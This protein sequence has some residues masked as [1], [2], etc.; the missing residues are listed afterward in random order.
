MTDIAKWIAD[1]SHSAKP[2]YWLKGVAGTG[3]TTVAQSVAKMARQT[4]FLAATF[5]FSRTSQDAE[6]RRVAAVIPTIAHQLARKHVKFRSRLRVAIESEPDVREKGLENQVKTLLSAD[7][8]GHVTH[9]LPFPLV[10]VLDALDEC[11]EERRDEANGLINVLLTSLQGLPFVKIFIT[12]RPEQGIETAFDHPDMSKS[13]TRFALHLDIEKA[14]VQ[15]DISHYLKNELGNLSQRRSGIPTPFPSDKELGELANRAGTLFI[16]ARTVVAFIAHKMANP[17]VQLGKILDHHGSSQYT[18]LDSL[19]LQVLED[20]QKSCRGAGVAQ[21]DFSTVLASLV[22][23]Q[24]SVPTRALTVLTSIE[25]EDCK[26]IIRSLSSVLLYDEQFVAPVHLVHQSFADFLVDDKR[27]VSAKYTFDVSVHHLGLAE[28]CLQTLN[29]NLRENICGLDDPS[30]LNSE[31]VKL[32]ER[33]NNVAP[34]QLRYSCR[35]WH[36]H[37]SKAMNASNKLTKLPS[38][39]EQFSSKHLLHWLELASLLDEYSTV[40]RGLPVLLASFKV[41]ISFALIFRD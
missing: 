41:R 36:V 14:I 27:C 25:E 7:V 34:L 24:E 35:F 13:W 11:E 38:S 1:S 31:V 9:T 3:K 16:Y 6:R 26:T 5:F 19:Y 37:L 15:S 29:N 4:G 20:A 30:L 39:L 8:L 21:Q 17:M 23:A 18:L 32:D 22:L 33:L 2:V 10:I 12:S 28:R 40:Q